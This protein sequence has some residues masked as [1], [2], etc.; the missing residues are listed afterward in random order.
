MNA[1]RIIALDLV[2][3]NLESTWIYIIATLLGVIIAVGFEWVLKGKPSHH[4]D[5]EAQGGIAK[6]GK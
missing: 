3:G 1:I 5:K 6:D 4:A 2:R